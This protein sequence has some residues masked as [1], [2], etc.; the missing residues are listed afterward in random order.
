MQSRGAPLALAFSGGLDTSYCVPRLAE[1]GWT[2]HTVYVN[3]GG[4]SPSDREAIR[5]QA[6]SVGAIQHHEIDARQEVFD[7]FVRFLVQ[8]N[9][10]RGEVYPLSVAAE[11]TQQALSLVEAARRIG[12]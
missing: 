12:A 3:T 10:L 8:G 4:A 2:V 5:R 1:A 9:V 6:E 7:R 11:R